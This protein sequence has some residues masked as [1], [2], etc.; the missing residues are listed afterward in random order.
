[1][2]GVD[3]VGRGALCGPVVAAA[4][5]LGE[6]F[7]TEGLDDSKRLTRRQRE[8]LDVRV[9]KDARAW[10]VGRAEAEEIDRLNIL[11]ASLL[12]MRRAVEGLA[13]REDLHPLQAAFADLFRHFAPRVKA[14]LMKSGTGEALAEEVTQE[15][16]ATLWRKAHMFDPARATVATWIFTIARNR[17]IDALRKQNRP[18]PEEPGSV[19]P[20][21]QLSTHQW[22]LVPPVSQT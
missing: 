14:F 19:V 6:G 22:V 4:V 16:M 2:A 21:S 8:R 15:V 1:M 11:Q 18:E 3:E 17:K 10:A 9:R 7:D 12:A 5:V 20:C 13:E